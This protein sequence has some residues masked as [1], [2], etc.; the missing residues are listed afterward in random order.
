M[1]EHLY[2]PIHKLSRTIFLPSGPTGRNMGTYLEDVADRLRANSPSE[3]EIPATEARN[4][5]QWSRNAPS[6]ALEHIIAAFARRGLRVGDTVMIPVHDLAEPELTGEYIAYRQDEYGESLHYYDVDGDLDEF[7]ELAD[8]PRSGLA[9]RVRFWDR[10]FDL[11][12]GVIGDRLIDDR[13]PYRAEPIVSQNPLDD[14]GVSNYVDDTLG[15]IRQ[16]L[17]REHEDQ[18]EE[19]LGQ[20]LEVTSSGAGQV[21]STQP[22]IMEDAIRC[23]VYIPPASS[24]PYREP[25]V[26]D[27][28]DVY[29]WNTVALVWESETGDIE[30]LDGL[31]TAISTA[32]IH[33]DP[34]FGTVDL[35]EVNIAGRSECSLRVIA[36]GVAAK[37]EY[38]AFESL[39][40]N[41]RDLLAG[42]REL[43]FASPLA[44]PFDPV[45]DLNTYQERAAVAALRAD[46]VF[47]I[48]GP[49]GTGKTR[50]LVAIVEHAVK[51]GQRVLVCAHSNQAVDN[52]VAGESTRTAVD[53]ASLHNLV[54]GGDD[55]SV[56]MI[57]IGSSPRDVSGLSRRYFSSLGDLEANFDETDIVATTTNSS[58]KL[59]PDFDSRFDLVVIDEATQASGPATAVPFGWGHRLTSDGDYPRRHGLRT[60]LAG[61]HKQLPPFVADPEMRDR[62]L[63]TSLFEH[64]LDVYGSDLA[65]PLYRQYRMHEDI[66]AFASQ[67]FYEG[68]LEHGEDNRTATIDDLPP[69]RGIDD[70][71]DEQP[72]GTSFYNPTEAN[73]VVAQVDRAL[74]HDVAPSDIG[75]ITGYSGQRA[76]IRNELRSEFDRETA[77]EVDVETIDKFQGGQ[78]EVIIVSF[79]RSNERSDSGFLESPRQEGRKRLN[80]ALTR[81]KKRLVLIGDWDTLAEPAEFRDANDS[82]AGTFARLREYLREQNA[83]VSNSN[84]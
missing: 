55:S 70:S 78:K 67:E 60:V 37:R 59:K 21:Q 79:V 74:R 18:L 5:D 9:Y 3:L 32:S 69:L 36:K 51:H 80:V 81:A 24:T 31:V 13:P 4:S 64:L 77:E 46:D 71:G 6:V 27:V 83:M 16:E 84:G 33:F 56:S 58:A 8:A 1:F 53:P 23:P 29:E 45:L 68:A 15:F 75:V 14:G 47:C 17:L 41:H 62:E 34:T 12:E 49:P 35:N 57:R 2:R 52:I 42:H 19:A 10:R 44:V 50:T 82:C 73:Y 26:Q 54:E 65:Q 28:Y 25:S 43:S 76:H 72:D 30:Y 39:G 40:A 66:A 20:G 11:P 7:I 48:H 38:K 63:H 61:D 22:R